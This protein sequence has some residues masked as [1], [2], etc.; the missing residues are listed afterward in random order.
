MTMD[1]PEPA[2]LAEAESLGAA[3]WEET[4]AFLRYAL[5]AFGVLD[6]A[7]AE[8]ETQ[9]VAVARLAARLD[10]TAA[11]LATYGAGFWA[12]WLGGDAR[13]LRGGDLRAV[14]HV[15]RAFDGAGSLGDLTIRSA[16]GHPVAP[17]E[18]AAVNRRLCALRADLLARARTLRSLLRRA[19][20][21]G[22]VRV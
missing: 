3:V 18:E 11:F 8:G 21:F 6:A 17:A 9:A 4:A 19:E 12:V 5:G 10:E 13:R 22:E 2:M 15:L 1:R 14:E 16:G 7:E 20:W